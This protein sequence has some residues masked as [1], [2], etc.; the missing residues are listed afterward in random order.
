MYLNDFNIRVINNRP[1][2]RVEYTK[3]GYSGH[4]DY[5]VIEKVGKNKPIQQTIKILTHSNM[6]EIID[7][8]NKQTPLSEDSFNE[9]SR[10]IREHSMNVLTQYLHQ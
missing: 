1:Q 8:W 7:Y 9:V 6:G 2:Y 3:D 4:C 5:D 10:T